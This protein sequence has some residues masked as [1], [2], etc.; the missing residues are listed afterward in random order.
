MQADCFGGLGGKEVAPLAM[1]A[2][3]RDCLG[4]MK[5][6]GHFSNHP[7]H[8]RSLLPTPYSLLPCTLYQRD[9]VTIT[10]CNTHLQY[11]RL[12]DYFFH[13]WYSCCYCAT[14]VVVQIRKNGQEEEK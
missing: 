13:L 12:F 14:L 11:C 5:K 3:L 4:Q 2:V 8:S 1:T 7:L 9:T 6:Q 10:Q